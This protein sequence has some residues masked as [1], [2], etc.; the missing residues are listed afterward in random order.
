MVRFTNFASLASLVSLCHLCLSLALGLVLWWMI[1]F[2]EYNYENIWKKVWQIWRLKYLRMQLKTVL[3]R[4][5]FKGQMSKQI[6]PSCQQQF[7]E[8]WSHKREYGEE[9]F[10]YFIII[11][12][13]FSHQT[14][15]GFCTLCAFFYAAGTTASPLFVCLENVDT[16]VTLHLLPTLQNNET[17]HRSWIRL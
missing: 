13:Y 15:Y 7:S 11:E 4:L 12:S 3:F 9:M 8:I 10:S 17:V 16:K 1:K 6:P 14:K 2:G 5:A